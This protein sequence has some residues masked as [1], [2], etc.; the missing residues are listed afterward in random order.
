[1]SAKNDYS[2]VPTTVLPRTTNTCLETKRQPY[3]PFSIRTHNENRQCPVSHKR[4]NK[5]KG[6]RKER[7]NRSAGISAGRDDGSHISCQEI[8]VTLWKSKWNDI[9][10]HHAKDQRECCC[11]ELP[12]IIFKK[13]ISIQP[14]HLERNRIARTNDSC[15]L[16][17]R[18]ACRMQQVYSLERERERQEY[19]F[20]YYELPIPLKQ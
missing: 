18:E 6:L 9:I 3:H 8:R 13:K 2:L 20:L 16:L 14:V 10:C 12:K 19:N 1:M 4:E 11:L 17:N 15:V 7:V 5:K